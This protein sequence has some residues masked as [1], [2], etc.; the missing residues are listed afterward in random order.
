[1]GVKA[2]AKQHPKTN[3]K[4]M[5]AELAGTLPSWS[6]LTAAP[7]TMAKQMDMPR[8][9]PINIFRRPT[10][11]WHRAARV[12]ESLILRNIVYVPPAVAANHPVKA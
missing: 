12:S 11:S 2:N 5:D 6:N 1:M 8:Q 3:M 4:A 7:A 10:K 9:A